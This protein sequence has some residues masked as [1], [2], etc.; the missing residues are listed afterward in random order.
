MIRRDLSALCGALALLGFTTH[1]LTAQE[2]RY[3]IPPGE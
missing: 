2:R 3:V 1:A